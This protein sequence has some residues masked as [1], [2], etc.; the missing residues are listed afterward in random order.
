MKEWKPP[1]RQRVAY[2][3]GPTATANP[4]QPHPQYT[5]P[6]PHCLSPPS[7]SEKRRNS[8]A[9]H[10]PCPSPPYTLAAW[11]PAILHHRAAASTPTRRQVATT[12]I[13]LTRPTP[14][15]QGIQA[16]GTTTRPRS[17]RGWRR[18]R[19]LSRQGCRGRTRCRRRT[20]LTHHTRRGPG[21]EAITAGMGMRR[22]WAAIPLSLVS[23][24]C[25]HHHHI[26][27]F[28]LV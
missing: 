15:R 14:R 4:A 2:R 16:Q 27:C 9:Y 24:S 7:M 12:P 18:S 23:F 20:Q 26:L 6:T 3:Q 11:T 8:T 28:M 25:Y 17:R 21:I 1:H 19:C 10:I 5:P 22:H 13:H